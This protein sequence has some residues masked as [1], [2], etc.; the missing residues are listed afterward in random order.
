[1]TGSTHDSSVLQRPPFRGIPVPASAHLPSEPAIESGTALRELL[2]SRARPLLLVLAFSLAFFVPL[3]VALNVGGLVSF[4]WFSAQVEKPQDLF[5]NP[6]SIT[7]QGSYLQVASVDNQAVGNPVASE[8]FLVSTW[9]KLRRL[10]APGEQLILF[11]KYE[12]NPLP[13]NGYAL[14][15]RQDEHALR[16]IVF[17]G[18]AA[19]HGRW[20]DFP[21]VELSSKD[22]FAFTLSFS[23]D[24]Y[25]G[26]HLIT[27]DDI[28]NQVRLLGGYELSTAVIPSSSAPLILGAPRDRPFRGLIGPVGIFTGAALRD[29]R[30]LINQ[31]AEVPFRLPEVITQ[32]K[33]PYIWIPDALAAD[34]SRAEGLP[35]VVA[36][37]EGEGVRGARRRQ[38]RNGA[39]ASDML[40]E[41]AHS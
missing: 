18:D 36:Y 29:S 40:S 19:T 27:T 22:W 20:Y 23:E 37:H 16:P 32:T 41:A 31:M 2:K 28:G 34:A 38:A 26:L 10:P 25:L 21:A 30:Q 1:M 11:S 6:F 12:G 39:V 8:R 5:S 3:S 4:P 35:Y 15:L 33:S 17:W 14:A 13:T 9:F 24:R 7:V